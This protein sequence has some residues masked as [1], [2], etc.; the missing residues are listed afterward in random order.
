MVAAFVLGAL[1]V[2]DLR[3]DRTELLRSVLS[4]FGL[5]RLGICRQHD[6][7]SDAVSRDALDCA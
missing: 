5:S 2:G 3:V 7:T 6:F 1:V 4:P